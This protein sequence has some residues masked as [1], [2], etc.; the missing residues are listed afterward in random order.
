[1]TSKLPVLRDLGFLEFVNRGRC[2]LKLLQR[3]F[4]VRGLGTD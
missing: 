2:R 4:F 1:M 3:H